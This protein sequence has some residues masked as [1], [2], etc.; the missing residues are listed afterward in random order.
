MGRQNLVN[1]VGAANARPRGFQVVFAIG[2]LA[3]GLQQAPAAEFKKSSLEASSDLLE[4][5]GDFSFGDEKKFIQLAIGSDNAIVVLHSPGGSV[6]AGI[7]IG[8][9]IRLKGFSTY[10]PDGLLCASACALAWLGGRSRLMSDTSKVGFHAAYTD[11]NGTNNVSSVANA[12][13]GAYLNQLGLPTAAII[14]ITKAA[15]SGMQWLNFSDAQG[16]G[17]DVRRYNLASRRSDDAPAQRHGNFRD[18]IGRETQ[19]VVDA[20]NLADVAGL[21]YLET[22]YTEQVLYYGKKLNKSD[23]LLDKRTFFQRWPERRY[24]VIPNTVEIACANAPTCTVEGRLNW[25]SSNSKATSSG[26]ASFSFTWKLESSAWKLSG[27][28]SKILKRTVSPK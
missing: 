18:Q 25:E 7:E 2:I 23:V 9:A 10:V 27:E 4:V 13:V 20:S 26:S 24:T 1:I 3:L 6:H 16:V 17:I 22:K 8:R 5:I 12:I 19:G 21:S 11:Q 28:S 15:P 14:Y